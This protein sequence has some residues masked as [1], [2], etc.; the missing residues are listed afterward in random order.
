MLVLVV[1]VALL[2]LLLLL[3][4]LNRLVSKDAKVFHSLVKQATAVMG[5]TAAPGALCVL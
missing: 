5:I 2:L 4:L 1:M 3:L